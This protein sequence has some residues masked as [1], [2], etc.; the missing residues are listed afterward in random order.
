MYKLKC[1][2]QYDGSGFYGYQRQPNKR[3]VQ[4]E[5]ERALT[6]ISRGEKID[7]HCSGRTDAGVHAMGQVF[8]FETDLKIPLK[9]WK[10]TFNNALPD[11]IYLVEVEKVSNDFHARYFATGKEYRYYILNDST[12]DVFK[13]N[14]VYQYKGKLNREAMKNA[15]DYFIGE[16][17]F[18]TFSS[19]KSTVKGNKVRHLKSIEFNEVGNQIELIFKGNG[20]LYHMVRVISGVI[21]DIGRGRYQPE[22]IPELFNQ[23]N[24]SAVGRTLAASGLYL[25][26]VDYS[27]STEEEKVKP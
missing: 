15:C 12:P 14:Y 6:Y 22:D 17:D 13:R 27:N 26:R 10:F 20:F 5:I 23:R 8:H 2:I 1:T 18:T 25:W 19:A 9:Q 24:R 16:H 21:V 3:T 7:T 4:G 11:D